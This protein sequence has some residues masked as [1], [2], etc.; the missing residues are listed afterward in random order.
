MRLKLEQLDAELKKSLHPVYLV[1]GDEPL[2]LGE[3]ADVIRSAVRLAEYH[4]REVISIDQGN[5]WS[6]LT[7]EADSLSIFAEKKL[8]DLR[9]PSGKPGSEGGKVLSAY[10]ENLPA[11][12]VLLITAGKLDAASQKAQWFQ[13]IDNVG[14]V[15]QVWP[16]QGQDLLNWLQRR[17]ESNGMRLDID[18]AKSLASRIEGNLLAA[19]QEIEKLFI[20]HG[21]IKIDKAMIEDAVADSARFDV[22]KLAEAVLAG[23]INRAVKVLNG[24]KAEGVAAPVVLWALSREARALFNVKTDLNRGGQPESVF[25]KHRIWDK[26]KQLMREAFQRLT[27]SQMQSLLALSAK[28]DRQIKGQMAGDGW[29]TLFE[30]CLTFCRADLAN[31]SARA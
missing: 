8:I 21:Q 29:D 12:T 23:K 7:V 3:A 20:L 22:F 9:L 17:A 6:Q 1:S 31:R 28:A 25:K 27:L 14:V 24:L 15:I 13:A 30:I 5:E 10:C 18:A 4:V 26:R 11:D 2:Q 16:L 19:A